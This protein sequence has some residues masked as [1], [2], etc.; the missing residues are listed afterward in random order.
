MDT[1]TLAST[2]R[3]TLRLHR[4]DD[5]ERLLAIHSRPDVSRYLLEEPW[6]IES[7]RAQLDRRLARTDLAEPVGALALVVE[8]EG[9]L[10]GTVALWR[11]ESEPRTLE[12]GWTLDPDHGGQG[13]AGEAVAAALRLAFARD[14]VHRVTAQMDGR[15][16]ASARL[17][18][19]V[20][21]RQEAHHRQ[22]FWSKGEWTDTLVFAMLAD[23]L[24]A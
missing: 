15:N 4:E 24:P 17:A 16:T 21:M 8:R 20:G 11:T 3:L 7:G 5:L 23:E 6:T 10:I 9:R 13:F 22:D 1:D 19:R 14:D 12:V 2:P 18:A